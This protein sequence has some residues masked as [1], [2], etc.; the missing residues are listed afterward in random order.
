MGTFGYSWLLLATQDFFGNFFCNIWNFF[1]KFLNIFFNLLLATL[2]HFGPY[3]CT[4][5]AILCKLAIFG[6]SCYVLQFWISFANFGN[7]LATYWYFHKFLHI[8]L[9]LIKLNQAHHPHHLLDRHYF[10]HF[11]HVDHFFDHFDDCSL[12]LLC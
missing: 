3:F 1:H 6:Y 5:F 2:G 12:I 9:T 7:F 8:L 4:F 11:Y 10:D